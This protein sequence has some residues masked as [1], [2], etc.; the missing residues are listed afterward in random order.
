MS[1]DDAGTELAIDKEIQFTVVKVVFWLK[2]LPKASLQFRITECAEPEGK[3]VAEVYLMVLLG[4]PIVTTVLVDVV[5]STP[6]RVKELI[7]VTLAGP[8]FPRLR[9]KSVK[10]EDVVEMPVKTDCTDG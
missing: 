2:V 3:F 7:L 9:V 1:I 10:Y 6:S 4:S 8:M 5:I